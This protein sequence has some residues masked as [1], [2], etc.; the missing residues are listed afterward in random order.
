[1]GCLLLS[2]RPEKEDS[3]KKFGAIGA[4]AAL[5]TTVAVIMPLTSATG[6]PGAA[7]TLKY[8]AIFRDSQ[9][10]NVDADDSG[11]DTAGDYFVGNFPLR[12]G[13][14][15]RGHLEFHC[16]IVTENPTRNLC[17]GVVHISGRGEFAVTDVS[18]ADAEKE[19]VAITGGTG[20]FGG[21]SGN[22]KFEFGKNRAHFTFKLK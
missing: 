22:G 1:V 16:A 13:G 14:K 2:H 6:T 5:A 19:K 21:A 18:N 12:Q 3:V 10:T 9:F 11:G 4:L 17:S 15:N 7:E 8:T 20:E